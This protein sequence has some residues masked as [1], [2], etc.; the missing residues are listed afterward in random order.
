MNGE[1][2]LEFRLIVIGRAVGNS[3]TA[4]CEFFEITIYGLPVLRPV[5]LQSI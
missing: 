5:D 1:P 2:F 4:N 3:E